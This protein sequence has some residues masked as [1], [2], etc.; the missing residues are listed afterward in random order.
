[1]KIDFDLKKRKF[2]KKRKHKSKK[3]EAIESLS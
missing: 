1:M 3:K 2:Q